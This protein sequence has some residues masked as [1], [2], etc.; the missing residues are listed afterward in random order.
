MWPHGH[1]RNA[2]HSCELFPFPGVIRVFGPVSSRYIMAALVGLI[3]A[4]LLYPVAVTV[5]PEMLFSRRALVAIILGGP[6]VSCTLTFVVRSLADLLA[7]RF[8]NLPRWHSLDQIVPTLGFRTKAGVL[9]VGIVSI[10]VVLAI[11]SS[12]DNWGIRPATTGRCALSNL[13]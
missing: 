6:V 11:S 3:V 5:Y 13:C 10:V 7:R 2:R 4:G 12:D 1:S 9:M 8:L